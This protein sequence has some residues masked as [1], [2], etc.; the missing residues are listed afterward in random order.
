MAE[1]A[2]VE[3]GEHVPLCI[4]VAR[5]WPP[6]SSPLSPNSLSRACAYR[7]RCRPRRSSAA[8]RRPPSGSAATSACP[9]SVPARRPP[10]VIVQRMGRDAVLDEAVRDSIGALVHGRDRRGAHRARRRAGPR[11]RRPAAPGR[12]A[13][14]LD[15][16]RRAAEGRARRLQGR[17]GRQARPAGRRRGDQRRDRPHPRALCAAGH[18][19][20]RRRH[21]RLRGHGLPRHARR[22]AVRRR[23]GPRP[24]GRARLRPPGARLRGPARGRCGRRRAHRHRHLPRGVRRAR[25]RGPGGAVR[26]D[27]QGGQGEGAARP[28]TTTSPPR[29]ASTRST[30]CARTS[31][32]GSTRARPPGSRPSSARRRS[33]RWSRPPRSICPTRWSRPARASSGTQMLHSLAHQGISRDAYLRI[34]GQRRGRD[35]RAAPS[36]TPSRRCGARPCSRRS[37]RLRASSPATTR[38]SRRSSRP[39]ATGWVGPDRS[40]RR[41]CSSGCKSSGRIETLKEDLAQR[42]ALDLVADAAKPITV[43]Q[44]QAREKLWTPGREE[45]SGP[46]ELWTPGR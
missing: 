25:A 33:T 23:R 35:R 38:C 4:V 19:R 27:R 42:K 7:R 17:R 5:R 30:S 9:A 34:A 41:S 8:S 24:D 6:T 12:A 1:R 46:G 11:S 40:R 43:E 39:P 37:S 15:R 44:A 29:P 10:P 2:G 3:P 20:S 32:R 45:S 14:L 16:D 18:G 13:A 22:R 31:A 21:G 26:R 28:S 36:P